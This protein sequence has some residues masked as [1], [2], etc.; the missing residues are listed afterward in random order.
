MIRKRREAIING[1]A[2][3]RKSL[4]DYML[5]ISDSHPEFSEQDI[6]NEACT[7]M[8]AV[9]KITQ[10]I[11]NYKYNGHKFRF[12]NFVFQTIFIIIQKN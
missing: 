4:L 8:L 10:G 1:E 11:P 9:S 6:V 12:A 5:N 3:E 2:A 7:F